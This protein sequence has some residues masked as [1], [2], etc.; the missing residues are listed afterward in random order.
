MTDKLPG[1]PLECDTPVPALNAEEPSGEAHTRRATANTDFGPQVI[2]SNTGDDRS[3]IPGVRPQINNNFIYNNNA[4]N[5]NANVV[6]DD[7]G[8]EART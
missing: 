7:D 6:L 3:G 2:P 1:I 4:I 8:D 5:N